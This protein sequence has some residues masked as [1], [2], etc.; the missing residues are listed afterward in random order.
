MAQLQRDFQEKDQL[1]QNELEVS[2]KLNLK[3]VGLEKENR[4]YKRDCDQMNTEIHEYQHRLEMK[5][6]TLKDGADDEASKEKSHEKNE[7]IN[8][9]MNENLALTGSNTKL[10]E[11]IREME[12]ELKNGRNEIDLTNNKYT[13]LINVLDETEEKYDA[14]CKENCD[15]NDKLVDVREKT[16]SKNDDNDVFTAEL[17]MK[18]DQYKTAMHKKDDTISSLQQSHLRLKEKI[19]LYSVDYERNALVLLTEKIKDKDILISN[20]QQKVKNATADMNEATIL[21]NNIKG[22]NKTKTQVKLDESQI[23]KLKALDNT[24][25]IRENQINDAENRAIFAENEA[26][27]K[28]SELA[29]AWERLRQYEAG[30]YGLAEAVSEIKQIRKQILERD[31]KIKNF[32]KYSN[33]IEVKY[34]DVSDILDAIQ[35]KYNECGIDAA[36]VDLKEYRRLK[37]IKIEETT[38]TNAVLENEVESLEEERIKLKLQIRRL[39]ISFGQKAVMTGLT[40]EDMFRVEEYM[41]DLKYDREN[42]KKLALDK[43]KQSVIEPSKRKTTVVQL[44]NPLPISNVLGDK[45]SQLRNLRQDNQILIDKLEEIEESILSLEKE[46]NES[47]NEIKIYDAGLRDANDKIKEM[48]QSAMK[49]ESIEIPSLNR[50]VQLLEVKSI[51]ISQSIFENGAELS[52]SALLLKAKSDKLTGENETLTNQLRHV[53]TDLQGLAIENDRNLKKLEY[54]LKEIEILKEENK[55]GSFQMMKIP[56]GVSATSSD[57]IA[58]L[59]EQLIH[60]LNELKVKDNLLKEWEN[61]MIACKL[62]LS[63]LKSEYGVLYK[64]YYEKRCEWENSTKNYKEK[65]ENALKQDEDSK[66]KLKEFSRLLYILSKSDNEKNVMDGSDVFSEK[67]I[68]DVDNQEIARSRK[69]DGLNQDALKVCLVEY[70]RKIVLLQVSEDKLLKINSSLKKENG[71][72]T[73]D[74]NKFFSEETKKETQYKKIIASIERSKML[75]NRKCSELENELSQSVSLQEFQSLQEKFDH[76][77]N[78]YTALMDKSHQIST[79][80]TDERE[81]LKEENDRL[82][83]VLK[84]LSEKL[85]NSKI[86]QHQFEA[87]FE[88]LYNVKCSK[89]LNVFKIEEKP[90][91][92]DYK[93]LN[94]PHNQ[95]LLNIKQPKVLKMATKLSNAEM[96]A[97]NVKQKADHFINLYNNEKE[98]ISQLELRNEDVEHK[99][100]EISKKIVEMQKVENSLRDNLL[101]VQIKGNPKNESALLKLEKENERYKQDLLIYHEQMEILQLQNDSIINTQTIKETELNLLKDQIL[102]MQSVNDTSHLIG[103]LQKKILHMSFTAIKEKK[104]VKDTRMKL[105]KCH[106][107]LLETERKLEDLSISAKDTGIENRLKLRHLRT[108][109]SDLRCKYTNSIPIEQKSKFVSDLLS[110]KAKSKKADRFLK[111]ATE[112]RHLVESKLQSIELISKGLEELVET[113]KDNN[114]AEM[115]KKV[116]TWQKKMENIRLEELKLRR[117]VSS[118]Q[119]QLEHNMTK[120]KRVG[121]QLNVL[122]EE[123]IG[124]IQQM[125][126]REFQWENREMKLEQKLH[127]LERKHDEI[128]SKQ[129]EEFEDIDVDEIIDS[130]IPIG[131]Q[132][133]NCLNIIRQQKIRL[134]EYRSSNELEIKKISDLN[135]TITQ[136]ERIILTKDR[137]IAELRVRL[138]ASVDRDALIS[139]I[140]ADSEEETKNVEYDQKMEDKHWQNQQTV[141]IAEC[142]VS[143][144]QERLNMKE[145][146]I[147]RLRSMLNEQGL[148]FDSREIELKNQTDSLRKSLH[149]RA[150]KSLQN[151]KEDTALK[152]KI[153]DEEN[154]NM[155]VSNDKL[156]R[157]NELEDV[158]LS[159]ENTIIN[160]TKENNEH[161]VQID[162][163]NLIIEENKMAYNHQMNDVTNENDENIKKLEI[164][165]NEKHAEC[166]K[167]KDMLND[168]NIEI[169]RLLIECEKSPYNMM[170][171][172]IEKLRNENQLKLKQIKQLQKSLHNS[173][174]ECRNQAKDAVNSRNVLAVTDFN[175]KKSVEARTKELNNKYEESRSAEAN[176]KIELNR[177]IINYENVEKDAKLYKNS[178]KEKNSTIDKLNQLIKARDSEID[179][180]YKKLNKISKPVKT[181]SDPVKLSFYIDKCNQ[182]GQQ[183]EQLKSKHKIFE[184]SNRIRDLSRVEDD[185]CEGV[186]RWDEKKK[187][188]DQV[189]KLKEDLASTRIENQKL[190]V[191][192][193][194]TKSTY[195][196]VKKKCSIL[197]KKL[198][199]I[200]NNGTSKFMSSSQASNKIQSLTHEKNE[201]NQILAEMKRL[202]DE[203]HMSVISEYRTQQERH[204][205]RIMELKS[206]N[207]AIRNGEMD[208]E[209]KYDRVVRDRECL[210]DELIEKTD[211]NLRLSLEVSRLNSDIPRLELRAKELSK[212]VDALKIENKKLRKEFEKP[213]ESEAS[214]IGMKRIGQSGKTARELEKTIASLKKVIDRL[215]IENQQL[216]GHSTKSI[217]ENQNREISLLKDQL[218]TTRDNISNTSIISH[219][220]DAVLRHELDNYKSKLAREVEINQ[221]MEQELHQCKNKISLLDN[222]IYAINQKNQIDSTSSCKDLKDNYV[223]KYKELYLNEFKKNGANSRIIQDKIGINSELNSIISE[224]KHKISY[225]TIALDKTKNKSESSLD[226]TQNKA[227]ELQTGMEFKGLNTLNDS[228]YQTDL[229]NQNTILINENRKLHKELKKI[230]N[231]NASGNT[232]MDNI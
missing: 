123:K 218:S 225:L 193:S 171:L 7:M 197:E 100:S 196:R 17:N 19:A 128:M 75:I 77:S 141:K 95:I 82:C 24:V 14:L 6:E 44:S 183:L 66:I 179:S 76:M 20:L 113:L 231:L 152:L 212:Y 227:M 135:K 103:N 192:I 31:E 33:E 74:I 169:K 36:V 105:A 27:D 84:E 34:N 151:I 9:F 145:K 108:T 13:K 39:A 116:M 12:Q 88:K 26:R 35:D 161:R 22:K 8:R 55:T 222:E 48:S 106:K 177:N 153:I 226:S 214:V 29:E 25:K 162:N 16:L 168:A 182:L 204:R 92:G 181:E 5:R 70:V 167:L 2:E 124:L 199:T 136:Q 119:D 81:I 213:N 104:N 42:K 46:L 203:E 53:R 126:Q 87:A 99:F 201:L 189:K 198:M 163:L 112:K 178:I 71:Y 65:M 148:K 173:Q 109:I 191:I 208:F 195:H 216:K 134:V 30:E 60:N 11:K 67:S 78:D 50:I 143:A 130:N 28:D 156:K 139:K 18:I 219:H 187:F 149:L 229:I 220:S 91:K 120:N 40:T 176:A 111:E 101:Y 45:D 165:L 129:V 228:A 200:E 190:E 155:M 49:V 158:A 61:N 52:E 164:N 172:N 107:K 185:I 94:I 150:K 115:S 102:E 79:Q 72:L 85:K 157:L 21:L 125:E 89:Q 15:L 144:M 69:F 118:L 232:K 133:E 132:L 41:N 131:K 202:C 138:P 186:S 43:H 117:K 54:S 180:L 121:L 47:N 86:E 122:E 166:E 80:T 194:S 73:L 4:D 63:V 38:A 96:E 230:S 64:D 97:I 160:L 37:N 10:E 83:Q 98:K 215:K 57:V 174:I 51:L 175:F 114:E 68:M 56:K 23:V 224:L 188:M 223:S 110:L 1:L 90:V 140:T 221:K 159:Q 211:E 147:I 59:N 217:I 142:A 184:N 93:D 32:T 205:E 210:K 58:R 209:D 154:V 170:K 207:E 137:I 127:S 146:T 62:D 206:E 3:I